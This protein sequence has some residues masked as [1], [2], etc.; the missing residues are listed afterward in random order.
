MAAEN[1]GA[2]KLISSILQEAHEQAAAIE[3]HSTEAISGI[4][5]RLEEDRAAVRDEFTKK[6]EDARE[7]TLSTAR[8]NA[9]L[10]ARKDL[11]AG[12]RGLIDRA[13]GEAYARIRSLDGE[14]RRGLLKKLLLRECEG[15]ERV[16]PAA[17]DRALIGELIGEV[18]Y[19]GLTLGGNDPDITD[20]F[21]LVGPNYRKNCSF[22]AL[23]EEVRQLTESEA[24]AK[25]FS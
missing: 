18:G 10:T 1:N 13:Y 9:E 23:M 24:A 17:K 5:R 21:T 14:K 19:S 2:D 22:A 20:G 4:K 11:L 15:N 6:A 16:D 12:K 3:W 8:T 7:L 25:L